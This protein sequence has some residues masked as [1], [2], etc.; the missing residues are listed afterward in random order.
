MKSKFIYIITLLFL[1]NIINLTAQ[2]FS[3]ES[4]LIQSILGKAKK[5]FVNGIIDIPKE[6]TNE[7]WTYYNEY[8]I[9][10][11]ELAKK[12]LSLIDQ[13]VTV[14]GSDNRRDYK[15]IISDVFKLNA[16]NQ[17]IIQKYYDKISKNVSAKSALQFFQIE[18]YLRTAI[19]NKLYEN[20]PLNK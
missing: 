12:R 9:K 3:Q 10:R 20:I 8:E 6:K 18:E 14:F 11:Q 19:D 2:D 5:D 1:S 17:K 16:D 13:Y 4:K 7:F 15:K